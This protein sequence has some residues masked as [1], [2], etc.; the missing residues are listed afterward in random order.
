INYP[1]N[2]D[3]MVEH[4]MQARSSVEAEN[5]DKAKKIAQLQEFVSRFAAG[6]RSSQVQSRRKEMDRLAPTELKRSNIQRPYIRFEQNKAAGREAIVA[7]ELS[8]GFD[9]NTLFKDLNLEVMRGDRVAIIGGN[10]AGKTTL[11]RCLI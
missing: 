5:R 2:Y 1:G 9:G 3:D 10:G 8:K 6:Q 7:H 11:L 4:K